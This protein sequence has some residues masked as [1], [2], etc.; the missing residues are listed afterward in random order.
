MIGA[1]LVDQVGPRFPVEPCGDTDQIRLDLFFESQAV[2][3]QF[4]RRIAQR[5]L[6]VQQEVESVLAD[7]EMLRPHFEPALEIRIEFAERLNCL[8]GGGTEPGRVHRRLGAQRGGHL[9]DEHAPAVGHAHGR[10]DEH[11]D[12]FV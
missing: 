3:P 2:A 8:R 4:R 12:R 9:L 1:E 7:G 10:L 6:I 5:V 11:A